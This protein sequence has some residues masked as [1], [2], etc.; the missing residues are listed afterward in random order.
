VRPAPVIRRAL[1][2]AAC[3]LLAQGAFG[4][5]A[6][7]D[8]VP[9]LDRVIIV[10]MENKSYDV[11]RIQAYTTTLQAQGATF[12]RSFAT[13]HPSQ[14]NYL[15]LFAGWDIN[16]VSDACPAPGSPYSLENLGHAL[17]SSGRTWKAYSENLAV[18]GST[19]CSY[20]GTAS[21][22]LYVRKHEPWTY[23]N[24]V[25]HANERPYSELA[26][27]IAANTLPNLV[28][29]IP[30]NCHNTHNSSTPGC[31]TAAGDLW[32]STALPP[33]IGALGPNG[34]LILTWDEDDSASGNHILTIFLGPKVVP[35][36]VSNV[37]VS[38]YSV[39]RTISDAFGLAPF[40][41][42]AVASPIT[43]VWLQPTPAGTRS[44]GSIKA[45]YR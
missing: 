32:L 30:N 15:S 8:G 10:V 41:Q 38:H 7:A 22:G 40:N 31:N 26:A 13:S 43:D 11:A 42:A 34:L 25:N 12:A 37:S 28:Y 17:E 20:D 1:W 45:I 24:N 16:V 18:A 36:F 2:I 14:P 35:G 19:A 44:W 9:A 5:P 4:T 27:D 21:T 33:L 3:A 23:F 39:V 29:V 6:R